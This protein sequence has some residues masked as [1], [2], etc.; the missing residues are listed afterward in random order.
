[1]DLSYIKKM[2][3][4]ITVNYQNPIPLFNIGFWKVSSAQHKVTNQNVS[5]WQIDYDAVTKIEKR[6][7]QKNFL[8]GCL[9]SIQQMRR[10]HHPLVL[11]IL[12][13]SESIKALNFAAEPILTCLAY[14]D[15]FTPDDASFIAYQ[16]AQVMK[17]VHQNAK[18]VLFGL[19][20]ESI[21]LTSTLDL[22]LCNF[23]FASPIINEYGI[24]VLR[25]GDWRPSPFQPKLNF[26]SPELLNHL[27]TGTF[28]DVFSYGL[29]I[30]STYLGRQA[31]DTMSPEEF[32]RS[33]QGRPI[34]YPPNIPKEVI[35][36][37]NQCLSLQ[38]NSRP[39]FDAI[40]GSEI[41]ESL[42]LKALQ[43]IEIIVTK[44]DD[45][46]YV[47]YKGLATT[48]TAFSI[49]ILQSRFLPLFIDDVVREPKFGPILIPLI[50]EIGR[51]LDSYS[52]MEEILKPLN[53]LFSS[54][55]V[56][57]CLFALLTSLPGIMEHVDEPSYHQICFSMVNAALTSNA[58]SLHREVLSHV[59]LIVSKM[60]NFSIE[61]ELVPQIIELY[62]TSSD[63]KIVASC[64]KCL[65]QCL[66]KLNHD[67]FAERVSEKITAAWNRLSNPPEIATAT[68]SI[69][70]NSN[71]SP[72]IA[73]Q[74]IVPMV[75][76]LLASDLIDPPTQLQ[77]ADY[78]LD[79]INRQKNK[80]STIGSWINRAKLQKSEGFKPNAQ[81]AK[82]MAMSIDQ[83]EKVASS[84]T[85]STV[86]FSSMRRISEH[87]PSHNVKD[88]LA[89]APRRQSENK[90]G[91]S[92]F[93]GLQTTQPS[94]RE[95]RASVNSMFSGLKMQSGRK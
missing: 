24:A 64:L 3:A 19:D 14:E 77:L 36:L 42:P 47:F 73:I 92:M 16:L 60:S 45:D 93:A 27:Q 74:Y 81:Q 72:M 51:S 44:T 71:V 57:E 25:T 82:S 38:P 83:F 7:D 15:S 33:V 20:T 12:E 62:S 67:L 23:V 61:N 11:K 52:Y 65:A 39:N 41:F 49:R 26:S 40:L 53:P 95:K 89:A 1:M 32:I 48:L 6:A 94:D 70:Q 90:G 8:N 85:T 56:P 84:E 30:A 29:T 66:P 54:N 17:F 18:M 50:F 2:G 9:Q 63:V 79:T 75:S 35:H 37:I 21:V 55:E 78:I 22:K 46:R 69:L 28:S 80:G 87:E 13:L 59:P 68:V 31:I 43:Y 91:A 34:Q 4:G 86:T 10:I 76:E 5:L 58:A 88:D